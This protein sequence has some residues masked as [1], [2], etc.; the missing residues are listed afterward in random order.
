[1]SKSAALRLQTLV[2]VFVQLLERRRD[3]V[4]HVQ[5]F[6]CGLNF[7]LFSSRTQQW[8]QLKLT[9]TRSRPYIAVATS[10]GNM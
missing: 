4:R 1:M 7:N 10:D 9:H 5:R 3:I 6:S 2:Q 8:S